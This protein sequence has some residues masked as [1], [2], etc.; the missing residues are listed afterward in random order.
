MTKSG[1]G[2]GRAARRRRAAINYAIFAGVAVTIGWAGIALDEASKQPATNSLGMGLW[3]IAPLLAAVL[4]FRFH[5]DGAGPLG[6]TLRFAHR[7]RWFAFAALVYPV[8]TALIVMAGIA[9]GVATFDASGPAGSRALIVAMAAVVPALVLKNTI[10]ELTWRGFGTRTALA[11]GLPRLRS[12]VL[13]GLTWGLWHLPL[14]VHFM[15]RADFRTLTSLPWPLFIPIFFAGV[16]ASAV[17]LGELRLRTGSIWPGVVMHTVGGAVVNTL[18]VEGYL[19]FSGHGDAL[20][21]PAPNSMVFILLFGL[22]GVLLLRQAKALRPDRNHAG[23]Q[24]LASDIPPRQARFA[25]ASRRWIVGG[26]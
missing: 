16:I 1:P 14:Y 25:N 10:E 20:F 19:R 15:A 6:L 22:V 11:A 4:L 13:V 23:S 26:E 9:F 7:G 18:I 2:L 8:V 3:I 12:H 21:S 17:I 24:A 5:P